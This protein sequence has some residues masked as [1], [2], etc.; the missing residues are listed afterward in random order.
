MNTRLDALVV[1]AGP[2]GLSMA[3]ALLAQGLRVRIIDSAADR[4]Q[5]TRAIGTQARTLEVF[6]IG[7]KSD[8]P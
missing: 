4:A 5:E 2:V 1:G 8:A 6:E 3:A 7:G